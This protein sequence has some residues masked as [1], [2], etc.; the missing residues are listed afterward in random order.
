[1]IKIFSLSPSSRNFLITSSIY[2]MVVVNRALIPKTSGLYFLIA[3]MNFSAETSTPRSI[4]SCPA[5]CNITLTRVFPISCTSPLTVPNT[6][7]KRLFVE[8][9]FFA[10]SFNSLSNLLI[11]SLNISAAS[12]NSAI[13]YSPS[14]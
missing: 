12:I 7:F 11:T 13:K 5:A 10:S 1:M 4:T 3:S 2:L 8:A 14:S 6:I 9:A